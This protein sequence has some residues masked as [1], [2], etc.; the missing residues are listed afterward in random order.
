M[1]SSSSISERKNAFKKGIDRDDARKKREEK[2]FELRKSKRE[3]GLQKRRALHTAATDA[4][5]SVQEAATTNTAHP[6]DIMAL[7]SGAYV[8]STALECV[9]G[10]RKLLSIEK[11]PPIDEVIGSGVVPHLV[12][13][14]AIDA[15]PKLQFEAAWCLTNIASGTS[16]QT[17]TIAEANAIPA[18]VRLLS[19]PADDTR[20]QAIWALGNIAGDGPQL[21]DAVL[22]AGAL[23][24]LLNTVTSSPTVSMLRTAVWVISNLCRGKPVPNLDSVR[25]PHSIAALPSRATHR[26]CRPCAMSLRERRVIRR[27][28]CGA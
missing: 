27:Q 8:E 22:A 14:L 18:F 26:L 7:V 20:E 15:V 13:L 12:Q 24:S 17:R 3:E 2:G 9:I 6:K 1:S 23:T 5:D 21:R 25:A 10:L 16:A 4:N 11:Q 28:K 19:S